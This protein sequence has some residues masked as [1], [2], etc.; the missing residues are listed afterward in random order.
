M[1]ILLYDLC[2]R[3]RDLRFSPHC[4]RAKMAPAYKGLASEMLATPF[5]AVRS[6]ENGVSKTIPVIN[7]GERIVADSFEIAL[8]LDRTYRK[9]PALFSHP[10]TV[11]AAHFLQAWGF[12]ALHS[13]IVQMIL[14]DIH[15]QLG[16]TDR[17][18]FRRA[19]EARFGMSWKS[20]RRES[21]RTGRPSRKRWSR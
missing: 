16:D 17:D 15:D 6:I 9:R 11:A 12:Q 3:D 2:G 7:D 14:N 13:T 21:P 20:T 18:Y 8:Y 10:S 5:T 1:A 4:W 19:R